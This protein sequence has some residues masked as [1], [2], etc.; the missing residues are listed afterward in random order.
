[1]K[2]NCEEVGES[3]PFLILSLAAAGTRQ[4]LRVI[5]CNLPDEMQ[6]AVDSDTYS[7]IVR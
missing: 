6:K 2:K 4:I 5:I 1:M 3:W 7:C